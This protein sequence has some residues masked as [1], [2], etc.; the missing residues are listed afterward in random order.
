[1][2]EPIIDYGEVRCISWGVASGANVESTPFRVAFWGLIAGFGLTV[3][4][5]ATD[6]EE[7]RLALDTPAPAGIDSMDASTLL[8]ESTDS[9]ELEATAEAGIESPAAIAS[10]PAETSAESV[11]PVFVDVPTVADNRLALDPERPL[12]VPPFESISRPVPSPPEVAEHPIVDVEGSEITGVPIE[13]EMDGDQPR[14]HIVV[15]PLREREFVELPAPPVLAQTEIESSIVR[16]PQLAPLMIDAIA[17]PQASLLGQLVGDDEPTVTPQPAAATE[18]LDELKATFETELSSLRDEIQSFATNSSLD[19][20]LADILEAQQQLDKDRVIHEI[21]LL[22]TELEQMQQAEGAAEAAELAEVTEEP[23][24][25]VVIT[26]STLQPGKID[27]ELNS[28]PAAEAFARLGR[29]AGQNLLTSDAIEGNVTARLQGVVAWEAI[30]ALAH[31]RDCQI[32]N[33]AGYLVVV[34]KVEPE[35]S[36]DGELYSQLL[37]PSHLAAEEVTSIL[38]PLLTP[39]VGRISC[40]HGEH[41]QSIARTQA[42]LIVD[43]SGVIDRARSILADIDRPP[44]TLQIT[45]QIMLVRREGAFRDGVLAAIRRGDMNLPAGMTPQMHCDATGYCDTASLAVPVEEFCRRLQT[46]T[47][48]ETV[49]SPCLQVLDRHVGNISLTEEECR[50]GFILRTAGHRNWEIFG[51]S[52]LAVRPTIAGD[53]MIHLEISPGGSL[54]VSRGNQSHE[55]SAALATSVLI[56]NG[57]SLVIGEISQDSRQERPGV[58]GFLRPLR[59]WIPGGSAGVDATTEF[60]V[61]VSAC[62][63]H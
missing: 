62:I 49:A 51:G 33:D 29:E 46:I 13:V 60:V 44:R 48:A 10:A 35:G 58:S 24:P 56:P 2:L 42:V 61:V 18:A 45:A 26:P 9:S 16:G 55:T 17:S 7:I 22:R 11:S 21:N 59:Q 20:R 31:S 37:F 36:P 8:A 39:G 41:P 40:T 52:S 63:L 32:I 12:I 25:T 34:P 57:G 4:L 53:G 38:Q 47:D 30:L 15:Q 23:P 43:R 14:I 1:M 5:A 19:A 27:V 3:A 6:P 50:Q 28:V 54:D